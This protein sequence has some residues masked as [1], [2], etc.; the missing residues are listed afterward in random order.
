MLVT[1]FPFSY[2]RDR[3]NFL[4]VVLQ[5]LDLHFSKETMDNIC[6]REEIE[7]YFKCSENELSL[8]HLIR[9]LC[10]VDSFLLVEVSGHSKVSGHNRI[11]V[12]FGLETRKEG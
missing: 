1:R 3:V 10:F 11:T 9:Q 8:Y 4:P 2:S 12:L 5:K 6:G 7:E